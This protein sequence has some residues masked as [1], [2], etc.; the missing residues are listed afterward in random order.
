M[1]Q[2]VARAGDG[3]LQPEPGG[4]PS[5]L[6]DQPAAVVSRTSSPRP[7]PTRGRLTSSSRAKRTRTAAAGPWVS[8][9]RGAARPQRRL[10][11]AG[12]H[13]CVQTSPWP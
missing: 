6:Q 8:P 5:P 7:A 11:V 1:G 4:A 3:L 12:A 13:A 10:L 2:P 9:S